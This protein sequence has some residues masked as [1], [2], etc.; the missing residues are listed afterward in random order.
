M[1]ITTIKPSFLD[2]YEECISE[3]FREVKSDQQILDPSLSAL[4]MV[5]QINNLSDNQMIPAYKEFLKN[6]NSYINAWSIPYLNVGITL[7]IDSKMRGNIPGYYQMDGAFVR[8]MLDAGVFTELEAVRF[9]NKNKFHQCGAG[10]AMTFA[11]VGRYVESLPSRF[12]LLNQVEWIVRVEESADF[13]LFMRT[14]CVGSEGPNHGQN[15]RAQILLGNGRGAS[16]FVSYWRPDSKF[17]N[18]ENPERWGSI[19]CARR[20]T[21]WYIGKKFYKEVQQLKEEHGKFLFFEILQ[22]H[23]DPSS[24][25]FK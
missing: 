25:S 5:D 14:P 22:V 4:Q 19:S 1:P 6:R 16:E 15:P 21:P 23:E 13:D 10:V 7:N 2:Y 11:E 12:P 9:D 18:V 3:I 17:P 8:D 20:I 24:V